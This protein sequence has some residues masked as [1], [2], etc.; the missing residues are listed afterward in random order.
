M[1]TRTKFSLGIVGGIAVAIA[2]PLS[3]A[4]AALLDFSGDLYF[5]EDFSVGG[6]LEPGFDASG[7]TP[8]ASFTESDVDIN[9]SDLTGSFTT[10]NLSDII[11]P[12]DNAPFNSALGDG[13]FSTRPFTS[14]DVIDFAS[15]NPSDLKPFTVQA[16]LPDLLTVTYTPSEAEACLSQTCYY[17]AFGLF[18]NDGA[19]ATSLTSASTLTTNVSPNVSPA[20]SYLALFTSVPEVDDPI[21]PPDNPNQPPDTPVSVP[22]P[23]SALAF[24]LL[25]GGW[26]AL[27]QG[28]KVL[29]NLA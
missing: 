7:L 26:A 10:G 22:E 24:G 8:V 21:D 6:F 17:A 5:F 16:L 19:T 29:D 28:R 12:L 2:A 15:G 18:N 4:Q 14:D 1:S 27:R 20:R 23:G 9:L 13:L 3:P 11:G 25:G